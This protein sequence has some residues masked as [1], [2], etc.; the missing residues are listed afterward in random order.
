MQNGDKFSL[1]TWVQIR[2]KRS[3]T[4]VRPSLSCWI[5]LSW[6]FSWARMLLTQ[7]YKTIWRENGSLLFFRLLWCWLRWAMP[8]C[9]WVS[10]R[11]AGRSCLFPDT[12]WLRHTWHRG[13]RWIMAL[14]SWYDYSFLERIHTNSFT[15]RF[16]LSRMRQKESW[17]TGSR[18]ASL[19]G[20]LWS[21]SLQPYMKERGRA[22]R[23]SDKWHEK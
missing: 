23:L 10:W 6:F 2:E 18:P 8:R 11:N 7:D 9:W 14:C 1:V 15:V 5:V 16:C 20:E 3:R 13:L 17:G 12:C 19:A 4:P 22:E 21:S